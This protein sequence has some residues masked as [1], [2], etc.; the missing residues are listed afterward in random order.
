MQS[1]IPDNDPTPIL[2]DNAII[3]VSLGLIFLLSFI[4]NI[5]LIDL[6]IL[7]CGNFNFIE[8]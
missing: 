1:A 3:K 4:T 5:S 8:K 7:N 6:K 2:E